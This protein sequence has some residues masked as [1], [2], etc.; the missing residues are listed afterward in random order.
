MILSFCAVILRHA[1]AICPYIPGDIATLLYVGNIEHKIG[2]AVIARPLQILSYG[3]TSM[4][5]FVVRRKVNSVGS[6]DRNHIFQLSSI[7]ISCPVITDLTYGGRR[8]G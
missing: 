1:H 8:A 5:R 3:I 7:P 2:D 6:V 4:H